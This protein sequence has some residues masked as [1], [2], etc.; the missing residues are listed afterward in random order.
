M[1]LRDSDCVILAAHGRWKE[2]TLG[3]NVRVQR[4][5]HN[6]LIVHWG[7]VYRMT[8]MVIMLVAPKEPVVRPQRSLLE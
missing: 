1:K 7:P 5:V 4:L 8:A 2:A 6:V 3:E